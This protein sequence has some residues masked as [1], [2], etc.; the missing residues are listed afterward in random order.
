MA[1]DSILKTVENEIAKWE[2]LRASIR[3]IFES[4]PKRKATTKAKPKMSKAGRERIAEAQRKRWR[5]KKAAD[6]KAAK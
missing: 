2:K 1:V 6:K 5:A 3:A 4:K